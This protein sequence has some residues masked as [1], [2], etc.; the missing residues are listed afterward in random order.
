MYRRKGS[1][2]TE[3]ANIQRSIRKNS[4]EIPRKAKDCVET[5]KVA[6]RS[7]RGWMTVSKSDRRLVDKN[8]PFEA[9]LWNISIIHPK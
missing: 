9:Y 4:E 2:L 6:I 1:V 3:R 7:V 8:H 5:G